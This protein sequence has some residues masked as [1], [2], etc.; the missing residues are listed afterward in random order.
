MGRVKPQPVVYHPADRPDVEVMVD[1]NWHPGE[2]RMW[3]PTPDGWA[4]QVQ[5][6]RE[7]GMTFL[8]SFPAARIREASSFSPPATWR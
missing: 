1:G 5:W 7:V 2:L 3:Q 6:R 4:G 8:D